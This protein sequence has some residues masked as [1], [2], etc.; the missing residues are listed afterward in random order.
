MT[1]TP[2]SVISEPLLQQMAA[3]IQQE[4]PGAEVRL[5][6]SHARGEATA[7]P[8]VDLMI[9]VTD[10]W[11]ATHNWFETWACS[12]ASLLTIAFR[13]PPLPTQQGRGAS[14]RPGRHG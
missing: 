6:G 5:F 7:D 11:Y 8:D 13:S 14:F 3:E 9:I 1:T 2:D 10:A 12:G 4:I